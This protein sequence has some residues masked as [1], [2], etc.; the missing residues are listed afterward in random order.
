M[1]QIPVSIGIFAYNEENAIT[2][3]LDSVLK[4]KT[5]QIIIKEILVVSSG[6]W[7]KTNSIV[8][9]FSKKDKRIQLIEQF[10]RQGKSDAINLFLTKTKGNVVVVTGADIRLH[11]KSIEEI[12][13]PFLDDKVGM[14]G[15]HPV[16]T[17]IAQSKIGKEIALLWKLHHIISMQHPKCG[18]TVAFRKVI[19]AIPKQSA[20]D[21]ATIEVLLKLIGYQVVYA[22]RAIVYNKIPLN[23]NEFLTQRRRV[24]A[25][26]K[27]ITQKYNYQV[28]TMKLQND[29]NAIIE[30]FISHPQDVLSLSKLI[31]YE[32]M[33]R[34]LGWFDFYILNKNPYVW[35]MVK[36]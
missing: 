33:G 13:L 14:V 15:A 7:D 16:P 29:F 31:S 36:R 17:N 34:L 35:K 25:G 5:D 23:L 2:K 26:H 9:N 24:Y 20:V 12:A 6:S 4:Q 21:E 27:W 19:K 10:N 32:L 22:P 1:K 18:E 3:A 30:Y 11:S 28:S 8:R